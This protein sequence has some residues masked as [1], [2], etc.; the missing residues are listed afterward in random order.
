MTLKLLSNVEKLHAYCGFANDCVCTCA[1]D[2]RSLDLFCL[3]ESHSRTVKH[4]GVSAEQPATTFANSNNALRHRRRRAPAMYF[5][6]ASED[7]G[8]QN[9]T[10]FPC[11][12]D[13]LAFFPLKKKK[14]LKSCVGEKV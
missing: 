8:H 2:P 9:I 14:K 5:V 7:E 11:L 10:I 13:F 1:R 4:A 6:P 12:A 3:F